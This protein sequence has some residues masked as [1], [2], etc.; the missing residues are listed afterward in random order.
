MVLRT[1]FLALLLILGSALAAPSSAHK[2]HDKKKVEQ[3]APKTMTHTMSPE[4]HE[5][6][7]DDLARLE[8]E[9]ELPW[10]LRL[11]NWIG[12]LHPFAVHF[13]L[14]LFPISWVALML[15]RRRGDAEPLLRS[16][17]IVAGA[18]AMAAGALGWLNGGFSLVDDDPLTLWHRWLGTI[19]A[20][21]GAAVALWSWRRSSSAHSRSM[22][23]V[24]GLTTVL[25]MVQG[26]LG[27]ALIHG[28]DHL[29]W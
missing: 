25:L 15:G 6:V 13:P 12:R 22:V 29:N 17:I 27:S 9:R 10:Y 28:V 24:L 19:V 23:W 8:A 26:W 4:V 7:K 16:L 20:V 14:A 21:V 2:E 18:S 1:L 5:A 3:V 11:L